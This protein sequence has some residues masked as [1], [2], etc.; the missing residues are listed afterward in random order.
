MLIFLGWMDINMNMNRRYL[1][2]LSIQ[3]SLFLSFS[4]LAQ[5]IPNMFFRKR[6]QTGNNLPIVGAYVIGSTPL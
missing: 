1:I 4:S 6:V 3:S 2:K 5:T